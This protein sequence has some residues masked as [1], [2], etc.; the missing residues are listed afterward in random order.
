[1][2]VVATQRPNVRIATLPRGT[3]VVDLGSTGHP[4]SWY[5]AVRAAGYAGVILDC[6]TGGFDADY[7][8]ALGAG[9]AVA[10]FQGYYPPAWIQGP[11][12]ARNR[13]NLAIQQAN[14]VGYPAGALI[15]LDS[16]AWG[17]VSAA[18]CIEWINIWSRTIR[19]A[20]FVDGLYVGAG[21]PLT[22]DQLYTDLITQ[23][24]WKSG[25]QVPMVATR[26]YQLVQTSLND[27]IAG[28]RVDVDIVQPDALNGEAVFVA[29]APQPPAAAPAAPANPPDALAQQVAALQQQL[30]TLQGSV[31]TKAE[32][33]QA[34]QALAK[35]FAG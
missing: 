18:A 2:T 10:L 9:L 35:Q 24:Y 33:A 25:S 20:G 3:R 5:A 34:L 8:A 15:W 6:M 16:E 29:P 4:A 27:V 12:G 23:H 28:V 22:A 31:V 13:A 32:L 21:T 19:D 30:Q 14:R 7:E 11:A 1:M 17:S 26:G